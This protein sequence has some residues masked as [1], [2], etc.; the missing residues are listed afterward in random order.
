MRVPALI[1]ASFEAVYFAQIYSIE[2]ANPILRLPN[3]PV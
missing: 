2:Q 1:I 3:A